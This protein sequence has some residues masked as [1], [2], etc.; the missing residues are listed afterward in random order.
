MDKIGSPV[1]ESHKYLEELSG[2]KE[3]KN[4]IHPTAS[5]GYS[6]GHNRHAS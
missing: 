4:L 2:F 5:Q 3:K 1:T 6:H